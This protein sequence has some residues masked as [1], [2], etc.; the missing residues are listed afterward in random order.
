M[1]R[2]KNIFLFLIA[3]AFAFNSFGFII[4]FIL[5]VE[6]T[7]E[8]AFEKVIKLEGDEKVEV[9]SVSISQLESGIGIERINNREIR[10]DGKMYDLVKVERHLDVI[11]FYC[12]HDE[13][14]DKLEKEFSNNLQKNINHR[15]VTNTQ[16]QFNQQIQNTNE[17]EKITLISPFH[18][19]SY[20]I[21]L[22]SSYLL[23]ISKIL[24]PPPKSNL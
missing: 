14:E 16:I 18:K 8:N 20:P 15:S 4:Y 1:N 9:I 19:T 22:A 7:K 2:L 21:F 5:E 13:K 12:I 24:T 3:L 10:Y 17:K 11:T 23:D 6:N